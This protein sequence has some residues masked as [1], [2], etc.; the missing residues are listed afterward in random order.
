MP[1]ILGVS[2][3]VRLQIAAAYVSG[4]VDIPTA[5]RIAFENGTVAAAM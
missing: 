5:L 3:P 2:V 4:L 1:T